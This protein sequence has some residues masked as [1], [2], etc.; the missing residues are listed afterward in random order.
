M[1][2]TNLVP[3]IALAR[4][5][6]ESL[7]TI[8]FLTREQASRREIV[9]TVTAALRIARLHPLSLVHDGTRAKRPAQRKRSTPKAETR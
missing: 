8:G 4:A 3:D 5:A 9:V 6:L 1:P 7:A 2:S